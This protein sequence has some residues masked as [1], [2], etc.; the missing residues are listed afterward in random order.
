M[1]NDPFESISFCKKSFVL[2]RYNPG[3]LFEEVIPPI[4]PHEVRLRCQLA[5]E[6]IPIAHNLSFAIYSL[7]HDVFIPAV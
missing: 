4:R 5:M 6:H 3:P 2:L 1:D 7:A